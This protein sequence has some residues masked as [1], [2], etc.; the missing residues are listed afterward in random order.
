MTNKKTD[1]WR[2]EFIDMW[3]HREVSED[4]I[5]G[6]GAS[7]FMDFIEKERIKAKID[8]LEEVWK[9]ASYPNGITSNLGEKIIELK[10]L[11]ND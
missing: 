5:M 3:E 8:V 6:D 1:S 11:Q 9:S 4:S 10:K 2:E 7:D